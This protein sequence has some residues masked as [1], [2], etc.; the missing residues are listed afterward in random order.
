MFSARFFSLV[1][2]IGYAAAVYFKQPL[3][4]YYPLAQRWSLHDLADSSLGPAMSWYGWIC[5]AAIPA[6][7]S[8]ALIPRSW[9]AR[10]PAAVY[11]IVPFIAFAC[12]AYNERQWFQ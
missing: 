11:W 12:G 1:F 9:A 8:S 7:V 5:M 10:I 2:G 3:F 6:I 4:R